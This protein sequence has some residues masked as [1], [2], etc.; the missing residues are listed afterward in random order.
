MDWYLVMGKDE[1][2]PLPW[3]SQVHW[4]EKGGEP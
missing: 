2:H 4:D 1:S 3:T